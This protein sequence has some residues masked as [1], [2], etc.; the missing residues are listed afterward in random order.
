M[1]LAAFV[2]NYRGGRLMQWL[3]AHVIRRGRFQYESNYHGIRPDQLPVFRQR[4]A[5]T[6]IRRHWGLVYTILGQKA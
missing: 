4:L 1:A 2:E 5:A 3:R 6:R